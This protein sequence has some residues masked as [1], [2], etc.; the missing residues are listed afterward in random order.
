M[1]RVKVDF[2]ATVEGGLI[3]ANLKRATEP[4]LVG[5]DIEAFDSAEGLEFAGVVDHLSD[6]GRFAF[7]RMHWEDNRP[8][9]NNP[10]VNLVI[11]A[12]SEAPTVAM[13]LHGTYSGAADELFEPPPLLVGTPR[14]VFSPT[15]NLMPA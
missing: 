10:G 4:L 6:D 11:A 14:T 8:V 12:W 9:C 2:S 7:L 15:E 1:K 3:R 13:R 5:D